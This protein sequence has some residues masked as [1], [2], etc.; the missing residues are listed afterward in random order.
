MRCRSS[1][2]PAA[3]GFSL[4]EVL[5]AVAVVGLTAVAALALLD[6]ELRAASHA[7][8]TLEAQA[9]AEY[10]L[11]E[12]RLLGPTDLMKLQGRSAEGRFTPPFQDYAWALAVRPVAGEAAL[13]EAEARVS[14]DGGEVVLHGRFRAPQPEAIR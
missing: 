12:A 4:L 11:A 9:L 1:R 5:V 7:V 8:R 2:A 3:G 14:W 10:R 6:A 13:V